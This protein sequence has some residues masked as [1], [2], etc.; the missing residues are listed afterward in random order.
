M[1]KRPFRTEAGLNA[2]KG[3]RDSIGPLLKRHGF[4]VVGDGRAV[5][6]TAIT[7][8]ITA[9]HDGRNARENLYSAA[10]LRTR[11]KGSDWEATLIFLADRA[12][13][14]DITHGQPGASRMAAMVDSSIR[15]IG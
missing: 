8:I 6:G 1:A 12:K 10:Q 7:Q 14:S 15:L 11:L 2:E 3:M 13:A 4:D 5:H 9:R